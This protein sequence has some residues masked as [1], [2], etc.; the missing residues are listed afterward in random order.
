MHLS[1]ALS[2]P[3]L[4]TELLV[5]CLRQAAAACERSRHLLSSKLTRLN[6]AA[7]SLVSNFDVP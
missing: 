2:G 4:A 1:Q 5:A 3:P 6:A 7:E